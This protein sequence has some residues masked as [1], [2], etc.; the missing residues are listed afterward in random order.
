[1]HFYVEKANVKSG[2]VLHYINLRLLFAGLRITINN[3]FFNI[4]L[5]FAYGDDVFI[6][7]YKEN[8]VTFSCH[9]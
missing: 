2:R 3:Q 7:M 4:I 9:F 5:V 6:R 8:S 1:M